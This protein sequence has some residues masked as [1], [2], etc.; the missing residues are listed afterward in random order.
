MSAA[1]DWIYEKAWC[2]LALIALILL[3]L[4]VSIVRDVLFYERLRRNNI[5]STKPVIP[6]EKIE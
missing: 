3:S 5:V 4:L 1:L 6:L 2:V